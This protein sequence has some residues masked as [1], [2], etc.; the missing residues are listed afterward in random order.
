[1]PQIS[2]C[3]PLQAAFFFGLF[4]DPEDR[5]DMSSKTSAD[6]QRTIEA[7]IAQSV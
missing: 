5:G 6:F 7:G 3:Y 2:A 4:F 1:M